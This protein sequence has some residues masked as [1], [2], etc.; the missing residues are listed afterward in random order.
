MGWDGFVF[1]MGDEGLTL[2]YWLSNASALLCLLQRNFRSNGFLTPQRSGVS[3]FSNGRV[4]QVSFGF[5]FFQFY[6]FCLI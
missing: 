3:S 1:Q 2:P 4:A 6:P 5:V